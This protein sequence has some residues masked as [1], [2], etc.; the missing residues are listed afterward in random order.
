MKSSR[1]NYVVENGENT[2]FFNGIT[3]AFFEVPKSRTE[4]YREI[5]NNPVKYASDF[6]SFISK[7]K[8]KG[9]IVDYDSDELMDV[10]KKFRVLMREDEYHIMVL[11]TYQCNLRC[12]YCT[13]EHADLR[14]NEKLIDS[15][16]ALVSKYAQ[17]QDIRKIR[18]SWFGGEP[19]LEYNRVV[20]MTK[21]I[22][23]LA[24]ENG[25]TFYCEITTNGTLLTHDRIKSLKD[26]GVGCYQITIDGDKNTH[27]S[28]KVLGKT[29]AFDVVLDKI[30]QIAKHTECVLRFNYTKDNLKPDSIISDLCERIDEDSRA[31]IRF[32]LFKVWQESES[33]ISE[34]SLS[35]IIRKSSE[36]RIAPSLPVFGLCYADQKHFH[37]VFP[38]G[39][40][41][42]CDNESPESAI[43][44]MTDGTVNWE[45][46]TQS[47]IPAFQHPQYP[48]RE[49]EYVPVCWGP[50]TAKRSAMTNN[51]NEACCMHAD[52]HSEIR[53]TILNIYENQKNIMK[54]SL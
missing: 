38:N 15:I 28:I 10:E 35:R 27:D 50:C 20:S 18:L 26:A 14:I 12:W 45:G 37:C 4:V 3:E 21:L 24:E 44:Y 8:D 2:I 9:F 51:G 53:K 36:N 19:L 33:A 43:G 25:K 32:L 40:I 47:H 41:G 42:K 22:R 34:E 52:K 49:C 31:N 30:N 1:Y 46:N 23:K 16:Y 6:S 17:R 13:Q 7:M 54:Y 29:S 48:C 5:I 11:P 39:R